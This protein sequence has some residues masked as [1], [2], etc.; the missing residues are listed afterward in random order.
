[1]ACFFLSFSYLHVCVQMVYMLRQKQWSKE[2]VYILCLNV[3]VHVFACIRYC[4]VH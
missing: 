4:R 3:R 1:M 2:G